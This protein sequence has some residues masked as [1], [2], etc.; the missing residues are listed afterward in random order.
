MLE[1]SRGAKGKRQ[2]TDVNVLLEEYVNLAFHGMRAQNS[3]FNCT[4]ERD[5]GADVGNVQLIP[6]EIGRVFI[7]L[8]NNAFYAVH[9]KNRTADSGY[10][11]M[12]SVSTGRKNG[13]VVIQIRDNG[14]GI[15]DRMRE[16][17]FEP[18][19]TTKPTGSGTGLGLSLSY[20]IITQ[21]HGGSMTL[22]STP[23]AYSMFSVMLPA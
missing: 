3:E 22:E 8:L 19:F 2:P 9:E 4:L 5:Y 15:P 7:N 11:P 17:I 23:G 14:S 13:R 16:K 1:H 18:F 6:Q 10:Q 20:E 21:G 12:V